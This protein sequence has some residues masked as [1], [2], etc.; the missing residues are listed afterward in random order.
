MHAAMKSI[1]V[2]ARKGGSGKTTVA[3]Q[4]GVLAQTAGLRVAFIDLD[5]QQSLSQWW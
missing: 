1:A 3:I 5:P 2:L 4:V